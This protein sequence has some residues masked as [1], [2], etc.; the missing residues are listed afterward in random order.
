MRRGALFGHARSAELTKRLT[1]S[2]V[3]LTMGIIARKQVDA[4][5]LWT[6]GL[7]ASHDHRQLRNH[8]VGTGVAMPHVEAPEQEDSRLLTT[9]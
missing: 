4:S 5:I 2:A 1:P 3:T 9:C 6:S 8:L 7:S